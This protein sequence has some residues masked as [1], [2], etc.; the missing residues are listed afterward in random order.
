MAYLVRVSVVPVSDILEI[1]EI[2]DMIILEI[3]NFRNNGLFG[4]SIGSPRALR[5][6]KGR[7]RCGMRG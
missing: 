5:A 4:E 2:L 7:A 3:R 6:I 1:M